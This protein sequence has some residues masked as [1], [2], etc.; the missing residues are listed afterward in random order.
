[1]SAEWRLETDLLLEPEVGEFGYDDFVRA[2]DLIRAGE[3]AARAALP[4]IR[5]WVPA[6]SQETIILPEAL[7]EISATGQTSSALAK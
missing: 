1:M 6:A 7:P 2:Q 5:Q 3:A 4:Q